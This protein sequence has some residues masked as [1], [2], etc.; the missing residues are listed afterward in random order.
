MQKK[1]F[2]G[3]F[4]TDFGYEVLK[5]YGREY[6]LRHLNE[7]LCELYTACCHYVRTDRADARAEVLEELCDSIILIDHCWACFDLD[8]QQI[9][10]DKN[11]RNL[12]IDLIYMMKRIAKAVYYV[13]GL[14]SREI[15]DK[16]KL[17][18]VIRQLIVAL[19]NLR[20]HFADEID[21]VY[22]KKMKRVE[23]KYK[24]YKL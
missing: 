1:P 23:E 20:F 2:L 21:A 3:Y 4:G 11:G 15:T 10:I 8:M 16:K 5:K 13:E 18:V 19:M 6:K 14:R 24:S 22:K 7:E 9:A 12:N 17:D